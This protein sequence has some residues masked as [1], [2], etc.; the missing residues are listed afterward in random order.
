M[1]IR[2][3]KFNEEEKELFRMVITILDKAENKRF[4]NS[5]KNK[6][7]DVEYEFNKFCASAISI[8]NFKYYEE[9]KRN[10]DK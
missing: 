5:T 3:E 6:M 1:E 9:F 10:K 4:F 7:I 2:T 8:C